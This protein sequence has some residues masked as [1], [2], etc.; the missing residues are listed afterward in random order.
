MNHVEAGIAGRL[1][2][3]LAFLALNMTYETA[4]TKGRGAAAAAEAGDESSS[5]LQL[6]TSGIGEAAFSDQLEKSK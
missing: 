2:S 4:G 3:S 1:P 5:L 6:G